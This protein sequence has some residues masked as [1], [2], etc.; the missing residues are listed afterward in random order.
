MAAAPTD[1]QNRCFRHTRL[2]SLRFT[3]LLRLFSASEFDSPLQ[4]ELVEICL[5]DPSSHW[6]DYE[7]LSY[8][9]GSPSGSEEISCNGQLLLV[10]PN[11][12]SALRHLR[13]KDRD[14][15]LW[16]DS[17]SIDQENTVEA[18]LERSAQVALMGEIYSKA[19]RTLCWL[20]RGETYTSEVM[21]HLDRIGVCPSERGFR[22]LSHI[23]GKQLHLH[24]ETLI[25]HFVP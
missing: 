8:V 24:L 5:D 10:T 14:R 19:S 23:E 18:R 13:L 6:R 2:L 3:R 9:W 22:K 7:A 16:I 12:E 11:C 21:H 15:M 4:I 20:G 25:Q 17:I 1:N